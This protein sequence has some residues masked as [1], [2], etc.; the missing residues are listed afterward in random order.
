VGWKIWHPCSESSAENKKRK[1]N[2][3]KLS[4][5]EIC[6]YKPRKIKMGK[7]NAITFHHHSHLS[8]SEIRRDRNE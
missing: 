8:R 3:T 6:R 4:A 2:I 7:M 5:D 1:R